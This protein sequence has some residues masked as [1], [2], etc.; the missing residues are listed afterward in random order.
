VNSFRTNALTDSDSAQSFFEEWVKR[1]AYYAS[2]PTR[3]QK[4]EQEWS[5]DSFHALTLKVVSDLNARGLLAHIAH[6][7]SGES[8]LAKTIEKGC[9]LLGQSDG[10]IVYRAWV[11]FTILCFLKTSSA[12][13]LLDLHR[14]VDRLRPACWTLS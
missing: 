3:A 9:R 10:E 13:E 7:G 1:L 14:V 11:H 8:S 6:N 12:S 4:G 2:Y 5:L